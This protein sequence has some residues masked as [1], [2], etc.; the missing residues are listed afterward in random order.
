VN[1]AGYAPAQLRHAYGVDR[2]S[3]DGTGQILRIVDAFDDP[4]AASDL[5]TFITAFGLR[6]M[7]GLPGRPACTVAAGPHPCTA[8]NYSDLWY[9][10]L[11]DY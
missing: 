5:Q 10:W 2:V 4:T 6:P 11:P 7:N 8:A 3:A 1:P 9:Q